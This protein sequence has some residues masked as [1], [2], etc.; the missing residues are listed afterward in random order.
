MG[1]ASDPRSPRWGGGGR[2]AKSWGHQ[3]IFGS[4]VPD[5]CMKMKTLGPEAGASPWCPMDL[6]MGSFDQKHT[7]TGL[8]SIITM[9]M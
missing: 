1:T 9:K 3:P 4:V 5:D 8:T 7:P 6:P 2:H